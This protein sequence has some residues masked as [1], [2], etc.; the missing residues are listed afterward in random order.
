MTCCLTSLYLDIFIQCIK[1]SELQT[2]K[3]SIW[4]LGHIKGAL[5]KVLEA[6]ASNWHLVIYKCPL[7]HLCVSCRVEQNALT[8]LVSFN[9]GQIHRFL[10]NANAIVI[11]CCMLESPLNLW[12]PWGPSQSCILSSQAEAYSDLHAQQVFDERSDYAIVYPNKSHTSLGHSCP[13]PGALLESVTIALRRACDRPEFWTKFYLA[14][15]MYN[16]SPRGYTSLIVSKTLWLFPAPQ[17]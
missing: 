3:R 15:C 11:I 13:H 6:G 9:V 1:E 8:Q 12:I 7:T 5:E 10:L 17:I 16:F 14:A 2:L 4:R